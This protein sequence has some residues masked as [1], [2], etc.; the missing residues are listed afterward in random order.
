MKAL[1]SILLA[2]VLTH[3]LDLLEAIV[4]YV[5]IKFNYSRIWAYTA[6]NTTTMYQPQEILYGT[7]YFI[8]LCDN[9]TVPDITKIL[10]GL[11]K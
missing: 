9:F 7:N 8:V 6:V 10:V 11:Y 3:G 5:H 4:M 1:P 2:G